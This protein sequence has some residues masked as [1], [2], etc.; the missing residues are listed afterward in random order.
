VANDNL[1]SVRER[2]VSSNPGSNGTT[3][4][5]QTQHLDAPE[6]RFLAPARGDPLPGPA[7]QICAQEEG[8]GRNPGR[9]LLLRFGAGAAQSLSSKRRPDAAV[10]AEVDSGQAQKE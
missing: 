7:I 4:R 5:G 2:A 3:V 9:L 10:K 8:M 6:Q 1:D